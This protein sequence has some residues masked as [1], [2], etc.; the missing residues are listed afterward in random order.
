MCGIFSVINH[1]NKHE[2]SR[3]FNYNFKRGSARGP[4]YSKLTT[5]QEEKE[6]NIILGFHRLAINGLNKESNQ[7]LVYDGCRLICNGEIITIK[8]C[9]KVLEWFHKLILIVK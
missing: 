6:S 4:E 1:N 9:M 2:Y 5:I 3:L 8:N 7:P